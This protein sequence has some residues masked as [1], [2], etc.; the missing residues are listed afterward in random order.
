MK[1]LFLYIVGSCVK[2]ILR[3]TKLISRERLQKKVQTKLFLLIL[4]KIKMFL[5]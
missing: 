4:N 3:L 2:M 1:D 5:V